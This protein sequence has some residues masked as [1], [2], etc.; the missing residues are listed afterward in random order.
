MTKLTF[1]TDATG[2]VV[3]AALP[4]A[5]ARRP[6]VVVTAQPFGAY[7]SGP[8]GGGGFVLVDVALVPLES[9]LPADVQQLVP[10]LLACVLF[11]AVATCAVPVGGL[12]RHPAQRF[13]D[14]RARMQK[15]AS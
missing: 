4:L 2:A 9:G 1:R 11:A 7:A 3:G 8:R 12:T 13:W 10:W 5:A 14:K 15:H 6:E